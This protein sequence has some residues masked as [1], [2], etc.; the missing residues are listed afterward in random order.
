MRPVIEE[1]LLDDIRLVAEAQNEVS[2]TVLAVILHQMP[3]DRLVADRDHRL[4]DVFRVIA[5]ARAET[6]AE[7][8]CFHGPYA[9]PHRLGL[10]SLEGSFCSTR[11]ASERRPL[12][13]HSSK[14]A[15]CA[16]QGQA[17]A[18]GTTCGE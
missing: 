8:N 9:V 15:R 10:G 6:A 11:D 1:E 3:K 7:E 4:R 18:S 13:K 14:C 12:S 16:K 5:D 17:T 2:V